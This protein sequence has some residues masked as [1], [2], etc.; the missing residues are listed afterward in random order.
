MQNRPDEKLGNFE[1]FGQKE[2]AAIIFGYLKEKS[3]LYARYL[4]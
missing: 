2:F 1:N 4:I 3:E